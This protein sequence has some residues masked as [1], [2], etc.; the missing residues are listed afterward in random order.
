MTKADT[1]SDKQ[2]ENPFK[3]GALENPGVDCSGSKKR[4]N[5]KLKRIREHD[6]E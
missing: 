6:S 1:K 2:Y 5:G 3:S 4:R